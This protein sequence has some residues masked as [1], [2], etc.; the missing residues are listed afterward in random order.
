[1]I[2]AEYMVFGR[3]GLGG[4]QVAE[5]KR[6]LADARIQTGADSAALSKQTGALAQTATRLAQAFAPLAA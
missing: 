3:K 1:M 6:M 2:S 4:P 5:V